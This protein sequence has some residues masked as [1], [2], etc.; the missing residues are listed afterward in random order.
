MTAL[1]PQEVASKATLGFLGRGLWSSPDDGADEREEYVRLWG[2]LRADLRPRGA[3]EQLLVEVIASCILR[4]RRILQAERGLVLIRQARA[5]RERA[6]RAAYSY[7]D[8]YLPSDYADSAAHYAR[9]PDSVTEALGRLDALEGVIRERGRLTRSEVEDARDFWSHRRDDREPPGEQIHRLNRAAAG[10][11]K[12]G[13]GT[14]TPEQAGAAMLAA[15]A[16]E[17]DHLTARRD[18]LVRGEAAARHAH[19][20]AHA[21]PDHETVRTLATHSRRVDQELRIALHEL[22]TLQKARMGDAVYALMRFAST[23]SDSQIRSLTK[24][25]CARIGRDGHGTP[26]TSFIET[27]RVEVE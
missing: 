25:T 26:A 1:L 23:A 24:L 11:H 3:L 7:D 5:E 6:R 9:N 2:S 22:A 10:E 14:M 18:A 13:Q 27:L 8:D 4:K 15:I 17:R 12:A 21:V 16:E 20:D 19:L